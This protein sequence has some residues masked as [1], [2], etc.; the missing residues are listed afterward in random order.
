MR[1]I[2]SLA[3]ALVVLL[4]LA[5]GN[6]AEPEKP[7]SQPVEISPVA[8]TAE[9]TMWFLVDM[10]TSEFAG[11]SFTLPIRF[12]QGPEF[13]MLDSLDAGRDVTFTKAANGYYYGYIP[14][15][16]FGIRLRM[17]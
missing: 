2:V 14:E 16:G 8:P 11:E 5:C 12:F 9:P 17:S 1:S 3:V 10:G 13:P 4:M 6:G 15:A 7:P